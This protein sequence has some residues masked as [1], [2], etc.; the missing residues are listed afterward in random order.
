MALNPSSPVTGAAVTG[1][2]SPTY[3]FVE[4]TASD[5]NSRKFV[6]TAVGGTQTGVEVHSVGSPFYGIVKRPAN[7][8]PLGRANPTTGIV[9]QIPKNSHM[10]RTFKGA[11]VVANPAQESVID[12]ITYMN[13]P[14]GIDLSDTEELLAALSF[15]FGF[16]FANASGFRD[17]IL[18]GTIK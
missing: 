2:T 1:L 8:K 13:V 18:T 10:F 14:A 7:Y 6:V 12:V 16:G 9:S 5:N 17:L 11:T 3:T 15:H 4:D